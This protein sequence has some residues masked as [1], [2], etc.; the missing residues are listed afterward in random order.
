M[1]VRRQPVGRAEA[2]ETCSHDGSKVGWEREVEA[3][4]QG[5]RVT[6]DGQH[7]SPGSE[8]PSGWKHREWV[9]GAQGREGGG[10]AAARAMR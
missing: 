10:E 7:C 3:E 2:R 9:K 8:P 4:R 5:G 6:G 1:V